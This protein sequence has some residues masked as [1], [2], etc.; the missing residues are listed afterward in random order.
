VLTPVDVDVERDVT[1]LLVAERPLDAEVD[2]DATPL[3]V[4]ERLVDSEVTPL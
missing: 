4:V 3:F 2:R 1:P